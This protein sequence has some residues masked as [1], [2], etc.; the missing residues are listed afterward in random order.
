MSIYPIYYKVCLKFAYLLA[1]TLFAFLPLQT[2]S[3]VIPDNTTNTQI[4]SNGS[5]A[6]I[7]GGETRDT[8]LFHSFQDFSIQTG[9]E[10]FFN[11]AETINNIFSRVTGGGISNIDGLIRTN[12]SANFY[13][14]NPAGIVFNEGAQL[15]IGGSFFATT[16]EEIQFENSQFSAIAPEQPILTINVP[17]GLGFGSEPGDIIVQGAQN[18]VV[19]EIP[20]F[21]VITENIPEGIQVNPGENISLIGGDINFD[22]GGLQAP[23]GNI[24]LGSVNNNQD[25]NLIRSE[26]GLLNVGYGDVTR[27]GNISFNNAAYIDVSEEMA[28]N[29][30]IDGRQILVDDGSVILANTFLPSNNSIDINASESLQ[31][32]GTSGQNDFDASLDEIINISDELENGSSISSGSNIPPTDRNS[33]FYSISLI[34]SDILSGSNGTGNDI[35]INS[36]ELQVFDAAQVRTASFSNS[37]SFAG[38]INLDTQ[39]LLIKGTNNIDGFINSLITS[40]TGIG[41]SGNGGNINISTKSLNV[42]DGGR[43]KPDTFGIGSAG[44]LK[45]VADDVTLQGT[46]DQGFLSTGLDANSASQGTQDSSAGNIEVNARSINILDGALITTS[47]FGQSMAGTITIKT[48]ELNVVGSTSSPGFFPSGII[49][50]VNINET[51]T[52]SDILTSEAGSIN[53]DANHLRVLDGARIEA[54]TAG[55]NSGNININAQSIE[56]KGTRPRV[57]SFIGGLSTS[58]RPE[59]FGDGGNIELTTDSLEIANGSIIQAI[60]LGDGDGGNIRID[61]ETLS[62]SGFDRFAD[63]PVSS[64]RVSQ[65]SS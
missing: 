60:S 20:S 15:D 12:G 5:T 37:N 57:G 45:I 36:N 26:D 21:R 31:L 51:D 38:D 8:N 46:P 54:D 25:V 55:G 3:Q 48:E 59:A 63:I 58:T 6:E 18:N 53:I 49:A 13:L 52:N 23:G 34:A 27:F 42:E 32:K 28:G 65:I 44:N 7:T 24:Q 2:N 39:N 43:I 4:D 17:I 9:N 40:T 50:A 61:T 30:N 10:A 56:L 33:N 11:N 47:S 64:Q 41:T 35:N 14:I 62:I 22:G 1:T 29:I 16:A 19:I